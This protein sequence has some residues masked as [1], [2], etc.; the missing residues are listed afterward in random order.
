[1]NYL[2]PSEYEQFGLDVAASDNWVASASALIDSHCRR[3]TLAPQ[4]YTERLRLP[5][6]AAGQQT[7]VQL[8]F[9]P[10][11]AVA[12]ATSPLVSA[13]VRYGPLRKGEM[14]LS[15]I[16]LDAARVFQ[17]PG[18]WTSLDVTLL[19]YFADSGEVTLAP[20]IF[21]LPYSEIE[22]TYTAGLAVT[23][24]PVKHACA[25]LVRNAQATPALNVKSGQLDQMKLEY[26]AP[27]LLDDTVR[28]LLAPYV[29]Q[30][31]HG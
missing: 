28:A 4:Q 25:Q 12:P 17:L 15:D 31:M 5:T 14:P 7:A 16:A 23:P 20:N 9:I 3:P 2:D 30:R 19:D 29:A 27:T 6:A 1:M 26:F 8:T 24:D 22:L 11:V 18:A 13:R 10:L 21:G